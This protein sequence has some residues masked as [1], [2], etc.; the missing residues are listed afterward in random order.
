MSL[1]SLSTCFD[2]MLQACLLWHRLVVQLP[3]EP[4]PAMQWEIWV[5][6][7]QKYGAHVALVQ[8]NPTMQ[9]SHRSIV[10]MPHRPRAPHRA[11]GGCPSLTAMAA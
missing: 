2:N 3:S 9:L 7:A 6:H 5:Q 10:G 8:E 4:P 1:I 11:E